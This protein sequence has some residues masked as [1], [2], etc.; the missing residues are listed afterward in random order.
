MTYLLKDKTP[1]PMTRPTSVIQKRICALS[2]LIPPTEGTP[3]HCETRFE[4]F[5][6]GTEPNKV[7]SSTQTVAI[8][9]STNDLAKPGQTDNVEQKS[10]VVITDPTNQTFCVT[11][12]HPSPTPF[13]P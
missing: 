8:D 3:D 6:K 12:P 7:D 1:H 13:T 4:Y 5:I 9:K 10:E 11:C 2:G